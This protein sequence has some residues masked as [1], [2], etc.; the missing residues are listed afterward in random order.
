MKIDKILKCNKFIIN[1]YFIKSFI[2]TELGLDEFLLLVYYDNNINEEFNVNRVSD[3]LGIS[4]ERVMISLNNLI[5]KKLLSINCV[6]DYYGKMVE[7]IDLDGI[8]KIIKDSNDSEV[9]REEVITIFG[10]FEKGFGR[11]LSS[12]EVEII[13]SWMD[14]G[15][16]EEL[17]LGALDEALY[18]GA[19][20]IRYIDKILL[21]WKKKNYKSVADVKGQVKKEV[22]NEQPDLFDYD[23]TIDYD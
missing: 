2:S 5:T 14:N 18:N 17:I 7:V 3:I 13:N 16:K 10:S 22:K 6:K 4:E 19:S 12:I 21:E 8:Y 9:K 23:W 15:I 20:N 11:P 1:D